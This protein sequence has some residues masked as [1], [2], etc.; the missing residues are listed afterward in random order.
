MKDPKS[1]SVNMTTRMNRRDFLAGAAAATAFTIVPRHV[2]GGNGN[3]APSEK[4]NVAIIGTG[5]QGIVNMKQ[6]FNEPD[7]QIAALCDIN[8]L[9]DYSMFYYGG[10]A[11]L[12]PALN[13]VRQKYGQPCP[14]YR[15]YHQML[16]SEDIDA[17]L[18]ATPDH[19][20]AMVSLTLS[21][22]VNTSTVKNHSVVPFTRLA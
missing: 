13:L 20:H 6:L 3:I 7:V 17:V 2:L 14:T 19:S 9:S 4:V 1:N 12:K 5:G 8:E 18:V 10:T 22:K 16:D 21:P 15:N 11:G